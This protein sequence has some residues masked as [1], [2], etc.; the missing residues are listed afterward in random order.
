MYVC[1][2]VYMVRSTVSIFTYLLHKRGT[3]YTSEVLGEY[4]IQS[5]Y[6]QKIIFYPPSSNVHRN[7]TD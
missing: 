7:E 1:G 6:V 5:G 3:K 2:Y 4:T